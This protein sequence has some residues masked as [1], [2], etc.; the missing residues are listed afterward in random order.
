M[1]IVGKCHIFVA[2][3]RLDIVVFSF[4]VILLEVLCSLRFDEEKQTCL[5]QR[6][7]KKTKPSG[8]KS[9]FNLFLETNAFLLLGLICALVA[10]P[11]KFVS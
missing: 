11:L 6:G 8:Q 4:C 3:I 1:I 9:A 2:L 5:M 7:K 10:L